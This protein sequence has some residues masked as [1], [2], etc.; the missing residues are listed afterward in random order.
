MDEFDAD[1][2]GHA[3]VQWNKFKSQF[4]YPEEYVEALEAQARKKGLL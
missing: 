4:D 1:F 2:L 3:A